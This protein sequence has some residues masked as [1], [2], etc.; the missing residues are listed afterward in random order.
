[1]IIKLD[2]YSIYGKATKGLEK[3]RVR[4]KTADGSKS[5]L[6][7]VEQY[8]IHPFMEFENGC[9]VEATKENGE[10][11]MKAPSLIS[12]QIL[13]ISAFYLMMVNTTI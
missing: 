13:A 8:R 12:A 6:E 4:L 10:F 5:I 11:T 3:Y 1:M 9:R 7:N 2:L